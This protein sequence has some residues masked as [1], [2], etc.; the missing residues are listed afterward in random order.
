LRGDALIDDPV[1]WGGEGPILVTGVHRSGTTW[2]GKMLAASED[3]GY[4]SEPLNV[5]HRPGV[6]RNPVNHWYTYICE[7]NQEKYLTALQETI[8]FKYHTIR[9]VQSLRSLKDILRMGRDWSSFTYGRVKQQRA[10]LKDPFAVF[11]SYWF[12]K[13]LGCNVVIIVRHPAAFVSSI[14]RLNWLFEFSDLLEQPLLIRDLLLPFYDELVEMTVSPGDLI[15]Q[16]CLLWRMIYAT[17][18]NFKEQHPEFLV[19]RHEDI[20]R[21]PIEEFRS[22][23]E[24]LGLEFTPQIEQTIIIAS[25]TRNPNESSQ[26]DRHAYHLNSKANL[27]MW[28]QRLDAQEISRVRDLTADVAPFFYAGKDWE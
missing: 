27:E 26:K 10:L 3:I 4:I 28:K 8:K 22:I 13:S 2:V 14:K 1:E 24:L 20:A 16:S 15:E 23:Y 17:V 12:F 6:M 5:W 7:D 18:K 21:S 25:S 11:S 19:L 9:E